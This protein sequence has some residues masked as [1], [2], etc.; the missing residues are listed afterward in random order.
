MMKYLLSTL[1]FIAV[2]LSSSL[3][4]QK[5]VNSVSRPVSHELWNTFLKKHVS[6]EGHV[7]YKAIIQDK[8]ELDKYLT[9]LENSHPN[10]KWTENE[11]KAYW[12]NAYN[13]FTVKLIIDNYP[14]KSI[15]EIG[16][17][18]KSTWDISFIKIEGQTY[19]LGDIEHKIL[20]KEFDDPRI[21]FAINC[22]SVSCPILLNEA[23]LSETLDQQLNRAAEGFINDS[24]RNKFSAGL[25]QV[26]SIFNWFSEDFTKQ[27]TLVDYL[28]LYS[29]VRLNTKTK[30]KYLDYNWNLNE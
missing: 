2:F 18:L 26:S 28:N 14:L 8:S 22:A 20:R 4:A 3:Q 23:F 30:V 29:K 7:N 27:G 19:S 21:H 10:V 25:A 15:K 13:A 12:I 5:T 17:A 9:L 11:R 1:M 6:D 16:G 24:S